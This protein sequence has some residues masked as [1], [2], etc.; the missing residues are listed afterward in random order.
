[1]TTQLRFLVA[2]ALLTVTLVTAC[3]Q[4]QPSE[5]PSMSANPTASPTPRF[6]PSV[7]P[8]PSSN[9]E[10]TL[11]GTV[12]RQEIE[13]GCIYFRADTNKIFE[14][15]GGDPQVLKVG[16]RVTVKGRVRTDL[17]TICQMGPVL[18][19]VSSQPA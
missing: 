16:S 19:V 11:T 17:V 9:K 12:E 1:M 5:T 10:I 14:L 2:G 8:A 7:D 13:G 4:A 15:R 6:E 18:E 3:A